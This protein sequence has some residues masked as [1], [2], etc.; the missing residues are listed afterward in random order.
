MLTSVQ[1]RLPFRIVAPAQTLTAFEDS[2]ELPHYKHS[3]VRPRIKLSIDCNG[4][5]NTAATRHSGR[6]WRLK[7]ATEARE[8]AQRSEYRFCSVQLKWIPEGRDV[9][10]A[11]FVTTDWT[12]LHAISSTSALYTNVLHKL[13][14]RV[15]ATC[16]STHRHGNHA[17]Q[18]RIKSQ[19]HTSLQW[20]IQQGPSS[21]ELLNNYIKCYA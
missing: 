6:S 13:N 16:C 7:K 10:C 11:Y 1:D 18:F 15:T 5:S 21:I 17:R 2:F 8:E 20:W 3:D 9:Q 14:C 4:W 12:M 19:H